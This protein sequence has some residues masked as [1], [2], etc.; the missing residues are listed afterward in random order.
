MIKREAQ[1]ANERG[2]QWHAQFDAINKTI[3][4]ITKSWH[5][6]QI[7]LQGRSKRAL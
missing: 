1:K 5:W 3:A 2:N 6:T 7:E 4:K